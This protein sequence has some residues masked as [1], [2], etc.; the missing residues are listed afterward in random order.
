MMRTMCVMTL[1]LS[2]VASGCYAHVPVSPD[3]VVP[4]TD[5]RVR[6]SA[7]EADRLE[8]EAGITDRTFRG[9][10]LENGPTN[11]LLQVPVPANERFGGRLYNRVSVPPQQLLEVEVRELDRPKTLLAVGAGVAVLTSAI[12]VAFEAMDNDEADETEPGTPN[13]GILSFPLLGWAFR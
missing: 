4:G 8:A 2:V 12:V 13:R 1:V 10:V 6:V 7:A 9:E 3:E 5:V 11:L